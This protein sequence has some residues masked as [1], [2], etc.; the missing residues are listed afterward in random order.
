MKHFILCCILFCLVLPAVGAQ[1]MSRHYNRITRTWAT[2]P[3]VSIHDIQFVSD[4]NLAQADAYQTTDD[5]KGYLQYSHYTTGAAGDTLSVTAMVIA[6]KGVISYTQHGWTLLLHDTAANSNE[7][8]GALVRVGNVTDTSQAFL[9][10]FTSPGM[11]DIINLVCYVTEFPLSAAA[12][13]STTQL[14]PVPG[15]AITI[16]GSG[17]LPTH[18]TLS[19]TDFYQGAYPGGTIKYSKGE[20]YEGSLV[21]FTNLNVTGRVNNTRGTFQLT[22]AD[23]NYFSDYDASHYFTL[24]HENPIIPGDPSFK[25]P[26]DG[27]VVNYIRGTIFNSS[28]GESPRGYRICPIYSAA[29]SPDHLS[30]IDYGTPLPSITSHKRFPVV[31]SDLD[32]VTVQAK[33]KKTAGGA[34]IYKAVLFR[35][36]N[37]GPWV[38][39]TMT[40]VSGDSLWEATVWTDDHNPYDAGTFVHYFVKG[41]DVEGRSKLLANSSTL[42]SSDTNKGFFFY[43]V[44][45]GTTTIHDIQYTPYTNGRSGFLGASVTVGGILTAGKNELNVSGTGTANVPYYI[46]SGN[47]PWSGI[48]VTPATGDTAMATQLA[49]LLLGDSVQ[50]TGTVQEDFEIT[51]I[52]VSSLSKISSGNPVPEPVT[53][54]TSTFN[55]SVGNGNP[56]G[57]QWEGML[58][59]AVGTTITDRAK[60]PFANPQEFTTSDGSAG[61]MIIRLDGMNSYSTTVGD[62]ASEKIILDAGDQLDTLIGVTYFSNSRYKNDPRTNADWVA[63]APYQYSKDWNIVSIPRKQLPVMTGYAKTALYPSAVSDAYDYSGGYHTQTNLQ[64][65]RGYWLKFPSAQSVRQ[66]GTLLTRDTIAVSEGWNLVGS[67][68]SS[69]AGSSVTATPVG[70]TLSSFFG[71]SAGYAPVTS[72]LPS[73]GYWVKASMAGTIIMSTTALGKSSPEMDA[74]AAFNTVTISDKT[75]ASQTLY[76]GQDAEGKLALST[77]EMPPVAPSGLMDARFESGR[78]VETYPTTIEGVREFRIRV[79]SLKA[80]YTISWN[81]SGR[82]GH[83]YTI[84]DLAG[85]AAVKNVD[86]AGEGSAAFSKAVTGLVLRISGN[87]IF[88]E[89]VRARTEFS[90]PL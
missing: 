27:A 33:L 83:R 84:D 72:L 73:K 24:G 40:A 42:S 90:E 8:G 29:A 14:V 87:G 66:I 41:L 18:T 77:F 59:R 71:Y 20:K 80:P 28:G 19:L 43:N 5:S 63:G 16:I 79:S 75:G 26:V 21:R 46:Q 48:W 45:N 37:N 74:L 2:Y 70:N 86:L 82:E 62:T 7:W 22:D 67:L 64:T 34:E 51:K 36:I 9:D 23:G 61:E 3:D 57:E 13:N 1:K 55:I 54:P 56:I 39:D 6:P 65:G 25:V 12:M 53:I 38:V 52:Q 4:A 30:D 50:V 89:R 47:V 69:F 58:V 76:F 15:Q 78:A 68:G 49:T 31:V 44:T 88:P 81:V 17:D 35:S 11:G 60:W 10:G 85:G 32:T